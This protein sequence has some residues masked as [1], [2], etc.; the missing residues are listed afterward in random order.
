MENII[1]KSQAMKVVMEMANQIAPAPIAVLLVGETGVGKNLI[2][3]RIHDLSPRKDGRFVIMDG[4]TMNDNLMESELFGHEK[5]AFTGAGATK[6]GRV[7][8]ANGGT[9]FLNEVQNLSLEMQAKLLEVVESGRFYRAGGSQEIH[10]DFRLVVATNQNLEQLVESGRFRKDLYY[11]VYQA[12][13]EIPPLRDHKEDILPLAE[14]YV[15]K[16]SSE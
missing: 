16:Y 9:L 5:G 1:G 10:S 11:R 13:I 6:I 7:E 14:H 15:Q 8:I 2:A 3:H 12:I 4:A